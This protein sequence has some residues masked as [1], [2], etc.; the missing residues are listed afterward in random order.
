MK[1]SAKVNINIQGI[2]KK[3]TKRILDLNNLD[4]ERIL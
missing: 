1:T 3:L 4:Y 2:F